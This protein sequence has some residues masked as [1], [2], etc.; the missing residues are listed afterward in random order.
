MPIFDSLCFVV[1]WLGVDLIDIRQGNFAGTG[2]Y[3]C[4]SSN[5]RTLRGEHHVCVFMGLDIFHIN[6]GPHLLT[7]INPSMGK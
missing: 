2:E 3:D 6:P 1:L 5:G 4:P 7:W